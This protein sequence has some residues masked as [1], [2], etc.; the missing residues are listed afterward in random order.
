MR[1]IK[2][3]QIPVSLE[4]YCNNWLSESVVKDKLFYNIII[5][6]YG[7]ICKLWSGTTTNN[8][9]QVCPV[10]HFTVDDGSHFRGICKKPQIG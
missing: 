8:S 2:I 10:Q 6:Q 5:Y 4:M 9:N 7:V 3:E 1:I